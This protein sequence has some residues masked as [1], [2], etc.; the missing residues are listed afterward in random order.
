MNTRL[1]TPLVGVSQ[2]L[3]YQPSSKLKKRFYV[4]H[5][6]TPNLSSSPINRQVSTLVTR[7]LL[8]AKNTV[9]KRISNS[10]CVGWIKPP[11]TRFRCLAKAHLPMLSLYLAIRESL[12]TTG[13]RHQASKDAWDWHQV[14]KSKELIKKVI[15]WILHKHQLENAFPVSQIQIGSPR[16]RRKFSA[17]L[18]RKKYENL[19]RLKY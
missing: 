15:M 11:A 6:S 3:A 14:T 18:N 9:L 13:L 1:G 16:N 4:T 19:Q 10:P 8:V 7:W 12:L 2:A 17:Y 5:S